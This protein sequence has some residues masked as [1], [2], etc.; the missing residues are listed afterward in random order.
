MRGRE[1]IYLAQYRDYCRNHLNVVMDLRAFYVHET[2][3][4]VEEVF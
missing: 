3:C 1:V 4:H 2:C